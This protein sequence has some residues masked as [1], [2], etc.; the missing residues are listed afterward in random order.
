[1]ETSTSQAA[2]AKGGG[3]VGNR[4][5]KFKEKEHRGLKHLTC[6]ASPQA[7]TP[8]T[9]NSNV[10]TSAPPRRAGP[11]RHQRPAAQR[12]VAGM[13]IVAGGAGAAVRQR[14]QR[15]QLRICLARDVLQPAGGGGN[16]KK[17]HKKFKFD[18]SEFPQK[19]T[20]SKPC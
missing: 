3:G 6:I 8:G 13:D 7:T 10:L 18:F 16:H 1:M 5:D 11:S 20:K 15:V 19:K 17:K 2:R 4:C 9:P 14:R 12:V